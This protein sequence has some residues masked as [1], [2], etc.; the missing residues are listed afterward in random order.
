MAKKE[1][2]VSKYEE[3]M[4]ADV[5]DLEEPKDTIPGGDW[6]LR[7]QSAKETENE[8][9]DPTDNDNQHVSIV[10][11]SHVPVEPHGNYDDNAI[12]AGEWRGVPLFT[13]RYVKTPATS[14]T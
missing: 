11:L 8:D 1:Q 6:V 5:G 10:K 12:E 7:C 2:T 9:Y 4:K 13:T 14:S 3:M